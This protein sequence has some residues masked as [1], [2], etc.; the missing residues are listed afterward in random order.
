MKHILSL[1]GGID[2]YITFKRVVK[3]NGKQNVV[4]VYGDNCD[5]TLHD[6][7]Y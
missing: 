5:E 3:K 7:L 2:R 6:I 4:A 1:S